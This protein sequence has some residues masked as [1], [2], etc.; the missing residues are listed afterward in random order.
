MDRMNVFNWDLILQ[1]H[2]KRY[3]KKNMFSLQAMNNHWF[4]AMIM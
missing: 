4:D 2:K 1:L 3:S